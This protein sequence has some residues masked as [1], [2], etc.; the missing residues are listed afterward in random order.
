MS[1][2]IFNASQLPIVEAVSEL[3][4]CNP[5][6][7][8]RVEWERRAL[9]QAFTPTEPVWS[10]TSVEDAV[11]ANV[12]RLQQIVHDLVEQAKQTILK[13]SRPTDREKVLYEDLALYRLYDT[14][15]EPLSQSSELLFTGQGAAP[16]NKA[17]PAFL[18]MYERDLLL[19]GLPQR[20]AADAAHVLAC[21]FQL[22]RAF[23]NIF[24][25]LV[26]ASMPMAKLRASVWE[27]IFTHDLR[28]YHRGMYAHMGDF[29]TLV[30][31]ESG[32]GKELVARA[33]GR[34]R[35]L[36]FDLKARRFMDDASM[37]FHAVN[38]AALS[39]TLIESELFGHKRGSFTG[40][41][42]DRQGWLEICP[43]RGTVFLDEIG[44]LEGSIQVKLL[45][46]L[47]SRVFER[48][49]ETEPR[50]FEGKVIA[51]TNRDLAAEM[52]QRHFRADLYFRLCSD[53]I[54]TPSLR[55]QLADRPGDL[56]SLVRF[57]TSRLTP[58]KQ[59]GEQLAD[60][61]VSWINQSLGAE[62][63]WPG[64]FRELEQC[65]RNVIVHGCYQPLPA[66]GVSAQGDAIDIL[67]RWMKQG[68]LPADD[69]LTRYV[70]WIYTQTG[71][72][73]GTARKLGLD[74]RT[75]KA[76]VEAQL[77]PLN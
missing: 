39:P 68:D 73:E 31:G 74:R 53:V 75:I 6:T 37:S 28:R 20:T 27:S 29:A 24:H 36:P 48:L 49:G 15:R 19:P 18:E 34:S 12:T 55:E 21:F 76:R 30:T 65:V 67:A 43:P 17:W 71:S 1:M 45:R 4:Y 23:T 59:E 70:Q 46:V 57:V 47:Q 51:A 26:G 25:Y 72:Y 60:E 2:P 3:V 14:F 44:E 54:R 13:G 64:N 50:R 61:V 32:T 5:F 10:L 16:I 58:T 38:L 42:S 56:R 69:V 7:T 77:P 40:A 9:G 35:Y 63:A 11:T 33:I 22:R 52:N 62:Y 66:S 8:S 41:I